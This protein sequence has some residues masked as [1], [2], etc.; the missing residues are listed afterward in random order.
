MNVVDDAT[1]TTLSLIGKEETTE[2]SMRLLWAWI[3][4]YGIPEA[5]YVDHKNVFKTDR[6]PTIEEQLRG[7]VPLTQFSRACQKLGIQ[8]ITANSP[9]AKGRVER[10][11]GVYQDRLVKEFRLKKISAIDKANELLSCGF[12]DN[13]NAKFAVSAADPQDRHQPLKKKT[14]LEA[15]F[16]FEYGRTIANDYTV[17]FDNRFFQITKQ[18]ALPAAGAKLTVQKRLDGS[19]HLIYKGRGVEFV[20]ITREVQ[21]Q[22]VIDQRKP[23]KSTAH[24]PPADHPWRHANRPKQS[25]GATR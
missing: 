21:S 25:V 14:D 10:N 19:I 13:I 15:I 17:R 20:E 3:N 18:S 8:I 24:M 2:L 4:K 23:K 16:S 5:L 12:V 22:P 9:Q 7:E 6:K 1:K 11:H